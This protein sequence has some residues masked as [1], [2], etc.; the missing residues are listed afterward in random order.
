MTFSTM[1]TKVKVKITFFSWYLNVVDNWWYYVFGQCFQLLL[2]RVSPIVSHHI[3]ANGTHVFRYYIALRAAGP[4]LLPPT[5]NWWRRADW[6]H[7]AIKG[8][9]FL[10]L[11]YPETCWQIPNPNVI[12]NPSD[13]CKC[14]TGFVNGLKLTTSLAMGIPSPA[15]FFAHNVSFFLTT[16]VIDLQF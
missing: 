6:L 3:V 13:P 12:F 8:T 16:R 4:S 1:K 14:Y 11:L 9:S 15:R 5:P 10:I 2:H 7:R